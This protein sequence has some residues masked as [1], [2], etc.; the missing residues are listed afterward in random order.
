QLPGYRT[1]ARTATRECPVGL[2]RRGPRYAIT[3]CNQ[4]LMSNDDT[5]SE[6]ALGRWTARLLARTPRPRVL[7]GGLG[8]GFTLRSLLDRLPPSARVVVAELLPAVVRW[9]RVH[10]GHLSNHPVA[11][12]RVE[13]RIGDV[14]RLVVGRP[15]WDSI[16]LDVDNGPEW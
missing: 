1:L 4:V 2:H 8:M 5:S 13:L 12:L 15:D 3:S 7:V 10:L 6:R 14:V 16:V 9:N 11:D